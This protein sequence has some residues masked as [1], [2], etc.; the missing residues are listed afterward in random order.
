MTCTCCRE[1]RR[2]LTRRA[3]PWR[4]IVSQV[5]SF[6]GRL[7]CGGRPAQASFQNLAGLQCRLARAHRGDGSG[8]WHC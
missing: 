7:Y 8:R 3:K 4:A 1:E 2:S 6:P 5:E